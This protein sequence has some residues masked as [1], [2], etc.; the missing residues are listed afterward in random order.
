[1]PFN[2]TYREVVTLGRR[3]SPSEILMSALGWLSALSSRFEPHWWGVVVLRL[4]SLVISPL[5][6]TKPMGK[7]VTS[8]SSKSCTVKDLHL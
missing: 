3:R 5:T 6:V 2:G 1:M 4:M 8:N 7:G